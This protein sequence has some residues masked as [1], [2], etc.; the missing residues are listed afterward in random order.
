MTSFIY[1]FYRFFSIIFE[2]VSIAM[3]I[4][5]VTSWFPTVNRGSKF[6]QLIY[7]VTEFFIAPVRSLMW[8]IP[9]VRTF[10]LDL[11][12]LVTYILLGMAQ[13]IVYSAWFAVA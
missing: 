12:F 7:V 9:A 13:S 5:A 10:P 1:V 6:M 2:I 3:L 8:K 11:S 4:R